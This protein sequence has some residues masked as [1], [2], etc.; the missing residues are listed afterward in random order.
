MNII[1]FRIY[2]LYIRILNISSRTVLAE[3]KIKRCL[4][5]GR[6]APANE[7]WPDVLGVSVVFLVT[8]MFM[9][10][11]EVGT[12]LPSP[13]LDTHFHCINVFTALESL[14]PHPD[15]RNVWLE[16]HPKRRRLVA[17]R[18]VGLV[19]GELLPARWH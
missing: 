11:L 19:C 6:N 2:N 3:W 17:G 16:C 12:P 9:L 7:P 13:N 4:L 8:G 10:G 15:T 5:S 1:S 18:H 14:Q